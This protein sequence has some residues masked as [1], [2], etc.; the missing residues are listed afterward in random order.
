VQLAWLHCTPTNSDRR[1][2]AHAIMLQY[3][4]TKLLSAKNL[5]TLNKRCELQLDD[6]LGFR[7][8]PQISLV[9]F[10]DTD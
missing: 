1:A 10:F 9:L 7:L 8:G 2:E 4:Y 3:L 5:H 6:F